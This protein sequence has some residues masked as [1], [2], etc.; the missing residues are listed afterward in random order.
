MLVFSRSVS[1]I[2]LIRALGGL[3]LAFYFPVTEILVLD[4]APR[5]KRVREMG[6]FSV[7][8]G[9]AYLIGPLLGGVII[10]NFGFVKLF[11][12]SSALIM[13]A[14]LQTVVTFLPYHRKKDDHTISVSGGFHMMRQLLP[15]YALVVC[16]GIVF[17]II[18]T[19]FPGY[20]SSVGI[21]AVLI[22]GLFTAFGIVR[23]SAYA[24]SE[25]YL[26]FG[27]RKALGLASLLICAGCLVIGLYASFNAFLPAIAIMGGCFAIIFTL[28]ISLIS[29]HFP[30][31][32]AG[33]A[34]GS[35]ES[36]YGIGTAIGPVLAGV[37]AAV[38]NVKWSFIAASFFAILML[39]IAATG[40]MYSKS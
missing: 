3:G 34:V 18:T 15:W 14:F 17:S 22:G 27:E 31:E 37:V 40:K 10:Q 13:F 29:R 24:T 20:V 6:L 39:I 7:S 21:S 9:S 2:I 26:H 23:V 32:Q 35:Y 25:R 16:Y 11:L 12:V 33:A 36:V 1:D 38:S 28:S 5:E 8:G 30:D 4:L 19:I